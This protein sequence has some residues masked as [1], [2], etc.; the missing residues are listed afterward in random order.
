MFNN[1]K[2]TSAPSISKDEKVLG[3]K[4]DC[5]TI[6]FEEKFQC[7]ANELFDVFSKLELMTAFTRGDVKLDFKKNGEWVN[8]L[9][10]LFASSN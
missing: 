5:K 2:S 1:S 4:I 10:D 3:V 9:F 6:I 7:K 8:Y